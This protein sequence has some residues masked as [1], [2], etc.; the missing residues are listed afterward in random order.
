MDNGNDLVIGLAQARNLQSVEELIL[1][2][3]G[4]DHRACQAI[5]DSPVLTNL[6]TLHVAGEQNDTSLSAL[7]NSPNC[8]HLEELRTWG[9]ISES[10]VQAIQ[11][12]PFC[13]KLKSLN[14][15]FIGNDA[16]AAFAV[17]N[18]LPELKHLAFSSQYNYRRETTLSVVTLQGLVDSY[19]NLE[20]LDLPGNGITTA[21]AR[22]LASSPILKSLKKL[23]LTS[24]QL[25]VD[26][27]EAI[28]DSPFYN[29]VMK[30]YVRSNNLTVTDIRKLR[31][32]YGKSFG[33]MEP[34]SELKWRSEVYGNRGF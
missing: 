26:G 19:P 11:N 2:S 28:A 34:E 15:D 22:V 18:P 5:A 33:N 16:D 10:G 21:G 25:T 8:E 23:V 13:R 4:L 20:T 32:K 3:Y 9:P 31:L 14:F 17:P 6:R 7:V 27:V 30:L 1:R 12:G 24:N 29:K